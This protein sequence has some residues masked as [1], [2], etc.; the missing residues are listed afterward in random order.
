M[1]PLFILCSSERDLSLLSFLF[2]QNMPVSNAQSNEDW[3]GGSGY[4][5]CWVLSV[6]GLGFCYNCRVR[7]VGGFFTP[8]PFPGWPV[9]PDVD[10]IGDVMGRSFFLCGIFGFGL[11]LLGN[12]VGEDLMPVWEWDFFLC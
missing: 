2:L 6:Q 4:F 5:S 7:F 12:C 10:G 1:F 9:I 11:G 8:F 3:V